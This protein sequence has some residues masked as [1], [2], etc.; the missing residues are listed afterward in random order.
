M[1]WTRFSPVG[2]YVPSIARRMSSATETLDRFASAERNWYCVS[3]RISW[4]RRDKVLYQYSYSTRRS[5]QL[6]HGTAKELQLFAKRA[7]IRSTR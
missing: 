3:L 5:R 2:P 7:L 4:K 6:A 1:K